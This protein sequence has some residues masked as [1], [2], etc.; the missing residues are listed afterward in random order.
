MARATKARATKTSGRT[1]VSVTASDPE[2]VSKL[3]RYGDAWERYPIRAGE[4][5][6]AGTGLVAAH[7]LRYP[8]PD[9][10][11]TADCL[12]IDPP[13]NIGNLKTFYTKAA[14][15]DYPADFLHF[16]D[17][18]FARVREIAPRSCYIEI[19]NQ[20]VTEFRMRLYDAG[21]G[22]IHGW[23]VTYYGK[24]PCWLLKGARTPHTGRDFEGVDEARCIELIAQEEEYSVI[25]D[26]CMGRGLVGYHAYRAGR[27]FVGSELN[28][29]RL[30][31]LLAQVA[32]AGGTVERVSR[33]SS[34]G[35]QTS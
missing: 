30:A 2:S 33:D 6:R 17:Q 35:N 22:Y 7:D 18:L 14:N 12:F 10:L 4:T 15:P 29:R 32:Q 16:A 5:W 19:G 27:Q 28:P 3:W 31:V 25:G 8:L 24:H 20:H 13:W 9:F 34:S 26:L 11:K 23:P 21:Y 1:A